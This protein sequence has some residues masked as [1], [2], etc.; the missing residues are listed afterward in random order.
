[1]KAKQNYYIDMAMLFSFLVV[2]A[3]G[4]LRWI[5][6][7]LADEGIWAAMLAP[8]CRLFGI[9]HRWSGLLFVV[10]AF[11]H[12][13]CHWEWIVIMTEKLRKDSREGAASGGEEEK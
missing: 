8:G 1:M 10:L 4:F 2:T 7:P 3:T 12:I 5:F 13:N 9:L 11:Y 6:K